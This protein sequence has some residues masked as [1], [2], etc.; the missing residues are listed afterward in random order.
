MSIEKTRQTGDID[1]PSPPE[2]V[3][4]QQIALAFFMIWDVLDKYYSTSVQRSVELTA[5]L[6]WASKYNF[7]R[8]QAIDLLILVKER[9]LQ[10][11]W[12]CYLHCRDMQNEGYA[13]MLAFNPKGNQDVIDQIKT[14]LDSRP[15]KEPQP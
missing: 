10:Q 5:L 1:E 14:V 11:P 8:I 7:S 15:F 12:A 9:F 6:C 13:D 4:L 3:E 2:I